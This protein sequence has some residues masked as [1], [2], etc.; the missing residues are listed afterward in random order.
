MG[1]ELLVHRAANEK[2]GVARIPRLASTRTSG[3][4][5]RDDWRKEI[6]TA[7]ARRAGL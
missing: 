7:R 4:D 2:A 6:R 3:T 1:V 5:R